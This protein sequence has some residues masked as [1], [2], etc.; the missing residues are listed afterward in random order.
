MQAVFWLEGVALGAVHGALAFLI[1][2]LAIGSANVTPAGL[3]VVGKTV[4]VALLGAVTLERGACVCDSVR[5]GPDY[6]QRRI[7]TTC[8]IADASS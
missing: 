3:G 8:H 6:R 7:G 4:Y 2:Y 5:G 1:P